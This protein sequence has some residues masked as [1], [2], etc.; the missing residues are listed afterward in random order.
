MLVAT[1]S[2][3]LELK[4]E[5]EVLGSGCSADLMEDEADAL[6]IRVC[7]ASNSLALHVPFLVARNPPDGIG[8]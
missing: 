5:L 1:M 7:I 4:T 8:E 2:H 6:W 3:S